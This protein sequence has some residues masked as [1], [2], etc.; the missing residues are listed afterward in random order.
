MLERMG[1]TLAGRAVYVSLWP[2]TRRERRGRG[3]A[4]AWS[5]LLAAPFTR[6]RPVLDAHAGPA[7]DWRHAAQLGGLPVPALDLTDDDQRAVWF[8]GDVQTYLERDLQALRAVKNLADFRHLMRAAALRIGTLL[9]QTELGRD[10]GIVQ[11]QVHRFLNLMEASF[12]VICLPGF[13]ANRTRRL[14]KAPKRARR[15]GARGA[16]GRAPARSRPTLLAE[17]QLPARPVGQVVHHAGEERIASAGVP[18]MNRPRTRPAP[19]E[20]DRLAA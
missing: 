6:W 11:P 14:I 15:A 9:N 12:Q 7:E 18:M 10:V 4:G 13:S 19:P 3:R 16:R 8:S 17:G 20:R 5:E 2:F 1:D